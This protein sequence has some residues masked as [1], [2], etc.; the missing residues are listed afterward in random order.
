MLARRLSY[1]RQL[2]CLVVWGL[3]AAMISSRH[4]KPHSPET[5]IKI[6]RRLSVAAY[7]AGSLK[8][9]HTQSSHPMDCLYLYMYGCAYTYGCPSECSAEE[10]YNNSD[11]LCVGRQLSLLC[12]WL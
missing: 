11:I 2:L 12:V 6:F 8:T 4:N 10:Y 3:S 7:T 9:V 1:S 5:E